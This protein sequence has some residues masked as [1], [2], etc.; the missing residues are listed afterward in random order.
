M[1]ESILT[2]GVTDAAPPQAQEGI[3]GYVP[4]RGEERIP[5]AP[6]ESQRV[7][8]AEEFR[9]NTSL[10]KYLDEKGTVDPNV[11]AKSYIHAER[12]IGQDRIPVPKDENDADAYDKAYAAL[13]R[14][15]SPDEYKLEVPTD[16]PPGVEYDVEGEKYL[17]QLSHQNGFNNKQ[18]LALRDAYLKREA[19]R[20]ANYKEWQETSRMQ[21]EE[22]LRREQG[23][24]YDNFLRTARVALKEYGDPDFFQYLDQSGLGND[25]RIVR[26]FGKIGASTLGDA[27]LKGAMGSGDGPADIDAAI[28]EFRAKHNQALFESDHPEH[29]RRTQEL[30]RLFQRKFPE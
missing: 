24:N 1:S 21:A 13:G 5:N 9:T 12:M 2:E 11:L 29:Q 20:T 19:E 4:E 7:A 18:V 28:D 17:R 27:K 15:A 23:H 25:P 14:P 26:V 16:L 6:S 8:L 22:A 10:A 3:T 30:S